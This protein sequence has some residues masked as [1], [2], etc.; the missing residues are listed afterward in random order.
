M[1][2]FPRYDSPLFELTRRRVLA[3]A[4]WLSG[5]WVLALPK[6]SA[7]STPTD[8]QF[9]L[10]MGTVKVRVT[11]NGQPANW[12]SYLTDKTYDI[13]K[14]Y[15]AYLDFPFH[16][17]AAIY[18]ADVPQ[19]EKWL[20]HL[21]GAEKVYRGG[22]WVGGYNNSSGY[23][24]PD[25]GIFMEYGISR[26]GSPGLVFH[27]VGHYFF[28]RIPWLNEGIVSFAPLAM[29]HDGFLTLS[30]PENDSI[31]NHWGFRRQDFKEDPPV[32]QDFRDTR[33]DLFLFWYTKN[34]RIQFLIHKELGFERYRT[35][36][37]RIVRT[38]GDLKTNE[39]VLDLLGTLKAA[40][41]KE[42]LTGWVFPGPYS[43]YTPQTFTTMDPAKNPF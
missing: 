6:A 4:L 8:R 23:F 41:W 12:A 37:Q 33:P 38:A 39:Q 11:G 1:A 17:A 16:T 30:K 5:G 28:F 36:L 32:V 40:N 20:V 34:L 29:A 27:E 14:A 43:R 42:L 25:R 26:V 19:G 3:A 10:R 21:R 35:F 2:E 9:A 7:Q 31:W 13:L 18:F 22:K 15:E 24:G